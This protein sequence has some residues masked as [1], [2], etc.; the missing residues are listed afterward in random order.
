[1]A[2]LVGG[3]VAEQK[4]P[5]QDKYKLMSLKVL[6]FLIGAAPLQPASANPII[7]GVNF[8]H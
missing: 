1:M 5:I 2:M 3:K 4:W 7:L 8:A 6:I